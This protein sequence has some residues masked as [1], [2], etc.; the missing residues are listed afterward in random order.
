MTKNTNASIEPTE[1]RKIEERFNKLNSIC[2]KNEFNINASS[3]S[4]LVRGIDIKDSM[5][6]SDKAPVLP[7]IEV[8]GV[9]NVVSDMTRELSLY[10]WTSEERMFDFQDIMSLKGEKDEDLS[11]FSYFIQTVIDKRGNGFS[12]A[13]E[14][15]CRDW[16]EL[17]I[18][19]IVMSKKKKNS[20]KFTSIPPTLMTFG[21]DIYGDYNE[22]ICKYSEGNFEYLKSY[23]R[24]DEDVWSTKTYSKETMTDRDVFYEL[25]ED[26]SNLTYQPIYIV[27]DQTLNGSL[28]PQGK[29]LSLLNLII[30]LNNVYE[31]LCDTASA[32]LGKAIIMSKSYGSISRDAS[33]SNAEFQPS[34]PVYITDNEAAAPFFHVL[35]NSAD[36]RLAESIFSMGTSIVQQTFSINRLLTV[37]KR[38]MTATEVRTRDSYDRRYINVGTRPIKDDFLE[39][40]VWSLVKSVSQDYYEN[41]AD[42]A[43]KFKIVWNDTNTRNVVNQRLGEISQTTGIMAQL[44]QLEAMLKQTNQNLDTKSVMSE[45]ANL[46]G[47]TD[48]Q[49]SAETPS[50]ELLKIV[51]EN[52]KGGS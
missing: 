37:D 23:K 47:F 30:R 41:N 39:P 31:S 45:V 6:F 28:I 22:V 5:Q 9:R 46:T 10:N 27:K 34:F 40:L 19:V 4:T 25:T 13:L 20:F 1:W 26:V 15:M 35:D 52:I 7:G 14:Q 36:P 48:V 11:K 29:G 43:E 17:G 49:T 38:E 42:F 12:S 8:L 18:G 24:N 44:V 16:L 33:N 50:S 2:G 51:S 21:T 32:K 3:Y